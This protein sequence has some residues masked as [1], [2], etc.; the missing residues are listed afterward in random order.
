MVKRFT[1][2]VQEVRAPLP[3]INQPPQGRELFWYQTPRPTNSRIA[4]CPLEHVCSKPVSIW[5]RHP[6]FLG[7]NTVKNINKCPQS[8]TYLEKTNKCYFIGGNG[9][10]VNFID[11]QFE[12][13]KMGSM[14][15]AI[16][17][18]D[19]NRFVQCKLMREEWKGTDR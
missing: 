10:F 4:F 9:T 17:S 15:T 19:E 14:L 13:I 2:H 11:A 1:I 5:L 8:W 3:P 18:E 12:C 7:T 16:H 6:L